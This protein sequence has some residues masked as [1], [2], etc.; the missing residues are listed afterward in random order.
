MPGKQ[1]A[2]VRGDHHVEEESRLLCAVTADH[3]TVVRTIA[4][5][6]ESGCDPLHGT[7]RQHLVR[8]QGGAG[9]AGRHLSALSGR[10][11]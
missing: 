4:P 1:Q 2:L 8:I 7:R 6:V 11:I 10:S 5:R 3:E 9:H